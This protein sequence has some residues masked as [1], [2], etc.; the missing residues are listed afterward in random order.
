M[1]LSWLVT[2]HQLYGIVRYVVLSDIL[3][4]FSL[5]PC[6]QLAPHLY[7]TVGVLHVRTLYTILGLFIYP[8]RSLCPSM[9]YIIINLIITYFKISR[10]FTDHLYC[11]Y[12]IGTICSLHNMSVGLRAMPYRR[13]WCES[14]WKPICRHG[15]ELPKVPDAG[16]GLTIKKVSLNI[17]NKKRWTASKWFS[18][19][20]LADSLTTQRMN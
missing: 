13:W 15:K 1:P 20:T 18:T 4:L 10:W 19:L 3:E 17:S 14:C 16:H 9:A 12:S 8:W 11:T 2:L 7:R 5:L 6:A